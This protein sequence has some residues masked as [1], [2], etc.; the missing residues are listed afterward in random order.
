M[1]KTID[2]SMLSQLVETI[3]GLHKLAEE[4]TYTKQED[5]H[6]YIIS[7]FINFSTGCGADSETFSPCCGRN[8]RS[9][10][11]IEACG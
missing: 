6:V 2:V 7:K 5:N 8:F 10:L 11:L 9:K 4:R 1:M 3:E